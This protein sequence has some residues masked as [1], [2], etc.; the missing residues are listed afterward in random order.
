[1]S[2]TKFPDE[3]WST[4]GQ[5]LSPLWPWT[6]GPVFR[7]CLG[8]TRWEHLRSARC[9]KVVIHLYLKRFYIGLVV[10]QSEYFDRS[11]TDTIILPQR[12]ESLK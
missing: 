1:M 7:S 2:G 8:E 12:Q 5:F 11:S 9:F 4:G 10:D 6:Y 3:A